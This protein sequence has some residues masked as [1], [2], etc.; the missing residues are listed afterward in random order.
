MVARYLPEANSVEIRFFPDKKSILYSGIKNGFVVER[1]EIS[2]EI[3]LEED[4]KYVRIAEVFHLMKRNGGLLFQEL[5]KKQST[6]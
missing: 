6:I 5:T 3:K 4:I 2:A 1:A